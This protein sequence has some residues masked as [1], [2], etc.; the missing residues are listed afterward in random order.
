MSFG[1]AFLTMEHYQPLPQIVKGMLFRALKV[2][3]PTVPM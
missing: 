3:C 2:T 1:G